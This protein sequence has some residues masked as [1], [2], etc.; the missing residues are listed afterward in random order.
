MA[1]SLATQDI[2][3]H[4]NLGGMSKDFLLDGRQDQCLCC[5]LGATLN[6]AKFITALSHITDISLPLFS[7][8]DAEKVL[9][10]KGN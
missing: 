6:T 9:L 5:M 4:L 1:V 3:D 8:V 2:F 10:L 7:A